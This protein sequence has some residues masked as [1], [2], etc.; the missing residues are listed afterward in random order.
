MKESLS[1]EK[2]AQAQ[3]LAQSIAELAQEDLL[4]MA[5]TFVDA[6]DASL[7]G[8]NE[9]KIRD[10]LFG[11]AAKAYQHHLQQKKTATSEPV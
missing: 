10:L 5:R 7:F 3:A 2:E 1:P 9:F 6:D 11:I 4:Q 8:A